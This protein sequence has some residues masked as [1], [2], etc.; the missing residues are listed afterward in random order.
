[1]DKLKDFYTL[2]S[3]E[4]IK[5]PPFFAQLEST[6][7]TFTYILPGR[8]SHADIA[9]EALYSLL[10]LLGMVHD[11][12]IKKNLKNNVNLTKNLIETKNLFN[13]YTTSL[14]NNKFYLCYLLYF[15]SNFEVLLEMISSLKEKSETALENTSTSKKNIF[16]KT[17]WRVILGIESIKFALNAILLFK[18]KRKIMSSQIPSR[19]Y[20]LSKLPNLSKDSEVLTNNNP[21]VKVDDISTNNDHKKELFQVQKRTKKILPTIRSLK[22]N[23]NNQTVNVDSSSMLNINNFDFSNLNDGLSNQTDDQVV[24]TFL[25]SK[26]LTDSSKVLVKPI[27]YCRV[28]NNLEIFGEF[29][30]ILRPLAYAFFLRQYGRASLKPLF[31]SF[32]IEIVSISQSL[33]IKKETLNFFRTDGENRKSFNI[34]KILELQ[35]NLTKL[36]KMEVKRRIWLFLFYFLR[37]PIY[38]SFT[39]S[40]IDG[41]IEKYSTYRILNFFAGILKDYQDLWEKYFFYVQ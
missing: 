34:F 9:S 33:R 41:V 15:I 35:K 11:S 19:D 25:L 20:D 36:E 10:S 29:L 37:S 18:T 32:L 5:N 22:I 23:S 3:S 12:I 2:Y 7:K 27:D 24:E 38:E 40:R 26:G 28:L 14:M 31:I 16:G 39:K 21:T 8:F 6:I 17:R 1:M 30:Y 13:K 4:L